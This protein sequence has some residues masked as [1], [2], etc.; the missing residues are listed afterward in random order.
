MHSPTSDKVFI[1]STD[2]NE[3]NHQMTMPSYHRLGYEDLDNGSV[4]TEKNLCRRKQN[5]YFFAYVFGYVIF[6]VSGSLFF[7]FFEH[8]E[9]IRYRKNLDYTKKSFIRKYPEMKGNLIRCPIRKLSTNFYFLFLFLE[10][11]L[12][13]FIKVIVDATNLGISPFKN[14][15][16]ELSWSFGQSFLFSTTLVTTIGKSQ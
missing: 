9:E 11:D 5:F 7:N 1:L 3:N 15:S 14:A 16:N 6:L 2:V 10:N 13:D 4:C 8:P 12:E